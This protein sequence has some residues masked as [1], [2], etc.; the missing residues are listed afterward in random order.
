PS[1]GP[2][3]RSFPP[4]KCRRQPHLH[5]CPPGSRLRS[6]CS[7]TIISID[8]IKPPR[9]YQLIGTPDLGGA[10]RA[11]SPGVPRQTVESASEC[12][13]PPRSPEGPLG[14]TWGPK[15]LG[16]GGAILQVVVAGCQPG[17]A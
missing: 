5:P 7:S 14:P 9:T 8:T 16:P 1:R 4:E 11:P 6:R 12:R 3:S 2:R 15:R 17:A 10:P 13:A